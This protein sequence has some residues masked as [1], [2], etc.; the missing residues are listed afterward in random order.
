MAAKWLQ[1]I[2]PQKSGQPENQPAANLPVVDWR[3]DISKTH[4]SRDEFCRLCVSA[5]QEAAPDAP[6]EPGESIDSF[7]ITPLGA[8]TNTVFLS[9]AWAQCRDEPELRVETVERLARIFTAKN[10]PA[11]TLPSVD[12]IVPLVRDEVY[13]NASRKPGAEVSFA[14]EHFVGDLWIIYAIDSADAM[15]TLPKTTVLE[16]KLDAAALKPLAIENLR[17]ILPPIERHGDGPT[18]LLTAGGDYVAS[19]ILLDDIWEELKEC[20]DGDIVATIPSRDVLLFTGSNSKAGIEDM[21]ASVTKIH[22]TGGYLVS[23]TMFRL[24]ADGWKVFS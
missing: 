8:E 2:F 6:I 16:L 20:V 13:L 4:L 12:S 15:K 19:L 11:G 9:N 18:Y 23:N 3:K 14:N 5:F 21:R 10:D 22:E 1:K 7:R 17:R 24:T